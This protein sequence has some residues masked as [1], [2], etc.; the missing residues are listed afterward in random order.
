MHLLTK[1]KLA[2]FGR[3]GGGLCV[4]LLVSRAGSAGTVTIILG[5]KNKKYF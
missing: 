5:F 4:V 1:K 3:G 2:T